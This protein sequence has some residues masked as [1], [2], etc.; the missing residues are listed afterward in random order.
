LSPE[1]QITVALTSNGSVKASRTVTADAT[2]HY[3]TQVGY[4]AG[5][6]SGLH[7]GDVVTVTDA[8]TGIRYT[9]PVKLWAYFDEQTGVLV[10]RSEP[11]A[12][13]AVRIFSSGTRERLV[14]STGLAAGARGDFSLAARQFGVAGADQVSPWRGYLA[15]LVVRTRARQALLLERQTP[16][17][18]VVQGKPLAG[19]S[20]LLPGSGVVF[21]VRT[22]GLPVTRTVATAD[23]D[24]VAQALLPTR[25]RTGTVVSM[26]YS[27]LQGSLRTLTLDPWR[28]SAVAEVGGTVSGQGAPSAAVV[29][30]QHAAD[31][32]HVVQGAVATDGR[33]RIAVPHLKAGQF[34]VVWRVADPGRTGVGVQQV[35]LHASVV[36]AD[37]GT[38]EVS[39]YGPPIAADVRIVVRHPY[40]GPV[41]ASLRSDEG[42][43]FI[44]RVPTELT[45]GDVVEV[46]AGGERLAP[47]VLTSDF[48]AR[49]VEAPQGARWSGTGETGWLVG[50][51]AGSCS[52]SATIPA[53]GRWSA[54][55]PCA[56]E[57]GVT[58]LVVEQA[59][60]GETAGYVVGRRVV[61]G[62]PGVRLL[63]PAPGAVVPRRFTVTVEVLDVRGGS[64]SSSAALWLD[65]RLV[66]SRTSRPWAFAVLL[67]PGRH[68]IAA[69][70][71]D[72]GGGSGRARPVVAGWSAVR[73]IT[74]G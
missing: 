53:S 59:V 13:V 19:G 54:S 52:A 16:N 34:L 4:D 26:T 5:Q 46:V 28:F 58:A 71:T 7:D 47:L 62:A 18:T 35:E 37:V 73:Y 24:G 20:H 50:V 66:V 55:T 17:L 68:R 40:G 15:D 21:T 57:R 49:S 39:G 43:H 56:V 14:A 36:R 23:R 22:P 25:V 65:G 33:F 41:A 32:V 9:Q 60:N 70:A 31:G 61:Q 42:G 8:H 10:G 2:G 64:E 11:G 38:S 3:S 67:A 30:L 29:V 1:A 74:T 27:G 63:A 44:G 51:T 6:G 12:S 45:A 48:T 69:V 72:D